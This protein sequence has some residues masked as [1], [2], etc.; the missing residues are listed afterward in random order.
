MQRA[1]PLSS[2]DD[3]REQFAAVLWRKLRHAVS[4]LVGGSGSTINEMAGTGEKSDAGSVHHAESQAVKPG[5]CL[6]RQLEQD[7]LPVEGYETG[8]N[9]AELAL[10]I[11]KLVHVAGLPPPVQLPH[12]RDIAHRIHQEA[13]WLLNLI[14]HMSRS[15]PRSPGAEHLYEH[16]QRFLRAPAIT[17][18]LPPLTVHR[19][20]TTDTTQ[21]SG[22]DSVHEAIE[23]RPVPEVQTECT[24]VIGD[25]EGDVQTLKRNLALLGIVDE[26]GVVNAG[27]EELSGMVLLDEGDAIRKQAPD[28]TYFAYMRDLDQATPDGFRT[29]S[30]AGNHELER[31]RT[32]L[33]RPQV[34]A[35]ERQG[36]KADWLLD[37][38][39]GMD[40]FHLKAP[41]LYLHGYPTI[42]F[43]RLLW[44]EFGAKQK[45]SE[46]LNAHFRDAIRK[47]GS[48]IDNWCYKRDSRKN[49]LLYDVGDA[50]RY[51]ADHAKEMVAICRQ[52]GVHT[53]VIGHRPCVTGMQEVLILPPGNGKKARKGA[54]NLHDV[55]MQRIHAG[56]PILVEGEWPNRGV[57]I[58]RNDVLGKRNHNLYGMLLIR[59]TGERLEMLTVN[60]KHHDSL[61]AR[62]FMGLE[63]TKGLAAI[64]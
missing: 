41:L 10:P 64:A 15:G 57:V 11:V 19:L 24:L 46:L 62:A 20:P 4:R 49:L 48:N 6:S 2:E 37:V 58:L 39:K 47:G 21:D 26:R 3:K 44:R 43:M 1:G 52:L 18:Q 16:L 50:A 59:K 38:I 56:E 13:Q 32:G 28:G 14:M 35:I 63:V 22:L 53:I 12:W 8:G 36:M 23:T 9:L 54:G 34:K 27:R 33:N 55:L 61:R 42:E 17:R 31:L 51:F 30:L 25:T 29:V 60:G 5:L 40:V 7:P 45:D